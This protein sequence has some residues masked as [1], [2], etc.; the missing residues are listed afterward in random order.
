MTSFM[1]SIYAGKDRFVQDQERKR[2]ETTR[3]LFGDALQNKPDALTQLYGVD[4]ATA[5]KVKESNQGDRVKGA[6]FMHR[7]ATVLKSTPDDQKSIVYTRLMQEAK[8]NP[9][10]AEFTQGLPDQYDPSIMQHVDGLIGM[11]GMYEDQPKSTNGEMEFFKNL[12]TGLSPED[13]LKA[14][15]IRLKLDGG[16]SSAALQYKEV[17][18][19][20]GSTKWVAFDPNDPQAQ[21]PVYGGQPQAQQTSQ[22][23]SGGFDI[24]GAVEQQESGGNPFAVSPKGARGPMQIM[25]ATGSSPG[26]G[27]Q[28]MANNSPQENVR[29][30][31][32]YLDA[33]A[34]RYGGNQKLA[35]AAYNAG[36]GAVDAALKKAGGNPDAALQYLPRETQNYVPSVLG[37][38]GRSGGG[39]LPA[40][41]TPAEKARQV[42]QAQAEVDLNMKPR[43][44]AAT[45]MASEN[46][47][48]QA[49]IDAKR[50]TQQA[51]RTSAADA[52]LPLLDQAETYLKTATGSVMGSARDSGAAV[53][54]KS[55]A[56]AQAAAQLRIIAG[57]LT[58]KVPRMEGPQ[59]NIDVK[60]YQQMAGDLGN[61]LL[62][63]ETRLAALK[64]LRRLNQKYASQNQKP[65]PPK[66]PAKP[67]GQALSIEERIAR[68]KYKVD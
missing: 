45:T 7:A 35:L 19:P 46:A 14:R 47:R 15:R 58:S 39:S 43:I 33:M 22:P 53:F 51:D 5:L 31:R 18:Q 64:E 13:E 12:T 10:V 57:Q 48:N 49:A 40:S 17:T 60:L 59:S 62:P 23:A 16:A 52:T 61:E 36:P 1:D 24:Y 30:G 56:G 42:A 11:A 54:G 4:P 27:V 68:G 34:K 41:I 50:R 26:F 65:A 44:D 32:D 6:Q 28:P 67:A 38:M 66:A 25:P 9:Y 20:D 21:D 63:V 2:Q 37:R 29:M 8:A 55:T 3:K